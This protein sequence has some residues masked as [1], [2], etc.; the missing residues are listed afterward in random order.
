[1]KIGKW[2]GGGLGWAIGGPIGAMLGFAIGSLYD[3]KNNIT[4]NISGHTNQTTA[5]DFTVS[6]L[7]LSA[8]VMKADGKIL[9]SEL[10]YVKQFFVRQFGVE[11]TKDLMLVFKE[12]LKQEINL[13]DVCQQ[14][15]YYMQPPEKLQLLH[16]LF[17]IALADN[18]LHPNELS[19]IETISRYLGIS[20]SDLNSLKA[21]FVKDNNN[22]YDILEIAPSATDDEV[23]KAYRLMAI[24]YHPDKVSHLGPEHQQA[25][26]EKFQQLNQ[27]YETIKKQRGMK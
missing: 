21:M 23:K 14:I 3:D 22:A 17:G 15:N 24:K 8:A 13:Y 4:T 5:S 6:I 9:K 20:A 26:K 2:I 27:A 1:M 10:E 25:A 19:V 18:E 7:V 11:K 12:I 16:Y